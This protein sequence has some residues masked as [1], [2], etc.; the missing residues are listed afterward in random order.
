MARMRAVV[1]EGRRSGVGTGRAA[2][3]GGTGRTRLLPLLP[4]LLLLLLI[5]L[6]SAKLQALGKV[7]LSRSAYVLK[8]NCLLFSQTRFQS[9]QYVK[10]T[11]TY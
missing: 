11:T 6:L 1:G 10:L 3:C 7:P 9:T 5:L 8:K 2:E 4:R